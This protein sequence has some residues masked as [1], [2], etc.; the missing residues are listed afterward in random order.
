M[1]DITNQKPRAELE[2]R[3]M[4]HKL[5]QKQCFK[6]TNRNLF[7]EDFS[8]KHDDSTDLYDYEI[9]MLFLY[10]SPFPL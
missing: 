9:G 3:S 1:C 2:S 10:L 4:N 8:P 6:E 7:Q 5:K